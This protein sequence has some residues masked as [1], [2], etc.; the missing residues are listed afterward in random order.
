MRSC[1]AE[2]V[3]VTCEGPRVCDDSRASSTAP[4]SGRTPETDRGMCI[5]SGVE[6]AAATA[7][8]GRVRIL[9]GEA[10]ALHGRHVVDRHAAQVL[11]R[12][13]VHEDAEA[14][15]VDHEVVVGRLVLDEE[16]VL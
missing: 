14:A 16:P 3:W 12:E 9:E 2:E 7:A 10:R 6:G 1:D 15:V 13:R 11:R 8:P 4:A 5:R